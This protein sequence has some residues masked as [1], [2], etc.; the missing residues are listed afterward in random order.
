MTSGDTPLAVA[1]LAE[2]N[3]VVLLLNQK[4]D[5]CIESIVLLLKERYEI[6]SKSKGGESTTKKST[7]KKENE[8]SKC[9]KDGLNSVTSCLLEATKRNQGSGM[10]AGNIKAVE[11]ASKSNPMLAACLLAAAKQGSLVR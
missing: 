2:H 9:K 4:Y 8:K 1:L 11:K 6:N 10:L 5:V 3:E 7:T